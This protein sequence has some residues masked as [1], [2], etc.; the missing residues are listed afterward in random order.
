MTDE[1]KTPAAKKPRATPAKAK[2]AG[3]EGAA[4]GAAA[5]AG[6]VKLKDLIA[7]VAEATGAKKPQVRNIVEATLKE[8]SGALDKGEVMLLPGLGKLRVSRT[9]EFEKGGSV[10]SLKM[11]RGAGKPGKNTDGEPLAEVGEAS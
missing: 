11:R 7:R 2:A 3:A 8:I 5:G 4:E 6:G 10:V 1:T 9:R